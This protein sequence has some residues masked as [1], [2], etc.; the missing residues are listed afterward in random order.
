MPGPSNTY[1]IYLAGEA[2]TPNTELAVIDYARWYSNNAGAAPNADVFE[3]FVSDDDGQTYV[4]VETVGPT[5]PGTS[6]GWI[7]TGFTVSDFVALSSTV[8]VKF[9]ASDLNAASVVEAAIDDVRILG[10]SCSDE[11]CLAD[12][13]N[14]GE[15]TPAD[16]NAWIAAFNADA[17]ECDQNGDGLCAP[18]DFNAWVLNFNAGC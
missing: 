16:F 3:V 7:E 17:P 9:V 10:V 18:D 15:V 2:V 6:G 5:G 12:T 13:N 11:P 4:L 1:P 14:D 8:R